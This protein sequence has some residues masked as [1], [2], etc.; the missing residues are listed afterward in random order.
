GAI[1]TTAASGQQARQHID[2]ALQAFAGAFATDLDFGA[3]RQRQGPAAALA[4]G[5]AVDAEA[6]AGKQPRAAI[7][8][9]DDLVERA[10]RTGQMRQALDRLRARRGKHRT[11]ATDQLVLAPARERLALDDA[12]LQRIGPALAHFD[13]FDPR[14]PGYAVAHAIDIEREEADAEMCRC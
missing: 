4:Q 2:E 7:V 8:E 13:A 11:V 12:Q 3:A 9:V 1:E 6:G 10:A 5:H 14:Q